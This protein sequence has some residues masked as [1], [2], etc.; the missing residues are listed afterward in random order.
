MENR[1][2]TARSGIFQPG[3]T[4]PFQPAA[5]RPAGPAGDAERTL[6]EAERRGREERGGGD[7]RTRSDMRT[8][9]YMSKSRA[10]T[11]N[12]QGKRAPP[13]KPMA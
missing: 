6:S 3:N 11:G 4:C 12:S 2:I 1:R 9:K 10:E 5:F 7:S 13:V 8:S